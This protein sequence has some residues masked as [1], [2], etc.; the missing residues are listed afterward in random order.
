M[1]SIP[2][3]QQRI[4]SF[5]HSDMKR[6]LP[7]LLLLFVLDVNAQLST[8]FAFGGLS[9]SGTT[10]GSFSG[11][12]LLSSDK[13]CLR[14]SNG[15]IV[16]SANAAGSA[17]FNPTCPESYGGEIAFKLIPNPAPGVTRIFMIGSIAPAERVQLL[18]HDLAG[19]LVQ[20]R[21]CTGAD[22]YSGHILNTKSLAAGLYV[23]SL[24]HH[25]KISTLKLINTL[26]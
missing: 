1:W 8:S 5:L 10:G 24:L 11:P 18:I 13:G 12:V 25:D 20:S 26:Y 2:K 4:V 14:V 21:V 9:L 19:K 22:F 6:L 15:V 3:D 17:L 23:V 16:F 7:I